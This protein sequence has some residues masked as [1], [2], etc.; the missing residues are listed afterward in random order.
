MFNNIQQV[1]FCIAMQ[2]DR[3]RLTWKLL[4]ETGIKYTESHITV[5]SRTFLLLLQHRQSAVRNQ[6]VCLSIELF[7]K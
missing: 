7:L 6:P 2:V 4:V 1:G 5:L 3:G